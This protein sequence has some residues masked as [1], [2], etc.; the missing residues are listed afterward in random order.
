VYSQLPSSTSS[1]PADDPGS[2]NQQLQ[3]PSGLADLPG[4]LTIGTME[5]SVDDAMYGLMTPTL[6]SMRLKYFYAGDQLANGAVLA[7]I[8]SPSAADPFQSLNVKWVESYQPPVV[9]PIV[10]NRDFVYMEATGFTQLRDGE[11]VGYHLLHSVHFPQ[12]PKLR[13]NIRGAVS[14]CGLYR[15]RNRVVEHFTRASVNSGGLAPR[16]LAVKHISV[17]LVSARK[18]VRCAQLKKLAWL[19]RLRDA[20]HSAAL[21]RGELKCIGCGH[22]PGVF[23]TGIGACSLC[24]RALCASC[25]V[26]VELAFVACTGGLVKKKLPFCVHC[27]DEAAH[28]NPRDVACEEYAASRL[29]EPTPWSG[30]TKASSPSSSGS[31]SNWGSLDSKSYC[32]FIP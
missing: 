32:D 17:A 7:T 25:K 3:Q 23:A 29:A 1:S 12:T 4:L 31:D 5:G 24:K 6:A 13:R 9:R 14:I 19:L 20:D 26:K 16:S 15:Q 18:M 22:K 10:T 28:T 21:S 30:L 8:E 11:S 2:V 27:M